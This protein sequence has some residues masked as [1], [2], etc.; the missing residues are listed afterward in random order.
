MSNNDAVST[1]PVPDRMVAVDAL[2]G[3]DMFWIAGADELVSAL[4]KLSGGK[5]PIGVLAN[6]LN[7]VDWAG[8]HFEDL[9]FPL[10]V[11]I[12]GIS[13]TLSLDRIVEKEGKKKAY[14]R[15]FKRFALMYLLGIFY[16]RGMAA[17][18]DPGIRFVGVLHR[19]A[20][21]YMGASLLYMNLKLRGLLIT[22]VAILIGYWAVLAFT[23]VTVPGFEPKGEEVHSYNNKGQNLTNWIDYYYLPGRKWDKTWDPEGILSNIPAVASCLLGVFAG[24]LLKNKTVPAQKKV[25]YLIGAGLAMLLIG[26]VWALKFHIIKKL[27]TSSFILV[28]GGWS[29][30]MLAAFYQIVDIWGFRKWTTPFVWVGSNALAIYMLNNIVHLD[31]LALRFTGGPIEDML[32]NWGKLLTAIVGVFL[33]FSVARFLYKKRIFIKL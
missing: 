9:I 28:A 26:N 24:M 17:Y 16:H 27:W 3:F 8:F 12:I 2:R 21:S 32:G 1:A 25:Y 22:C 33:M 19:L 14:A 30:L 18:Y 29:C 15:V 23:N 7:H 5:G 13:V 31:E 4:S 6:Q 20:F 10:F 11:F